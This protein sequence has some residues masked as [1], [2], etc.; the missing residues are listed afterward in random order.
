MLGTGGSVSPQQACFGGSRSSVIAAA[1]LWPL[2][3][4]IFGAQSQLK[5]GHH[6]AAL[7]VILEVSNS[8]CRQQIMYIPCRPKDQSRDGSAADLDSRC[9]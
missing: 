3:I 9:G 4:S 7:I 8:T 1:E 6:A 5:S 2:R